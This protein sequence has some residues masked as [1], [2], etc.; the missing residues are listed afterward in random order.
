MVTGQLQKALQ[1]VGI[2]GLTVVSRS[3][4]MVASVKPVRQ[5]TLSLT[6]A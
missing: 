6:L 3:V 5:Q 1:K 4:S 2:H